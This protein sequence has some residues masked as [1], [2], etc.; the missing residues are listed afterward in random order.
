MDKTNLPNAR[1]LHGEYS[2]Y[3]GSTLL[4]KNKDSK[5]KDCPNK[6]FRKTKI[7]TAIFAPKKDWSITFVLDLAWRRAQNH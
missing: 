1:G 6:D 2:T 4:L 7:L 5:N 3:D